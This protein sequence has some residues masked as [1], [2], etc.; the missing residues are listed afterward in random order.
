LLRDGVVA[1]VPL[2]A[3]LPL[4]L[5]SDTAYRTQRFTLRHGDRL[6][7]TTDGITEAHFAGGSPFGVGRVAELLAA[8]A[9]HSPTEFVR[10][11]TAAVLEFRN[12]ELSDDATAV[13]LDW[14]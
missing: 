9:H 13:C 12:G 4:G 6:L 5:Y 2:V 14:H 10:Q 7:L 3:D 11:L 8:R 1:P